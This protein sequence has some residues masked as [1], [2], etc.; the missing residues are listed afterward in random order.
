V[1]EDGTLTDSMRRKVNFKNTMLIM[2]SN[3]GAQQI[4]G[5][6]NLGFAKGDAAETHEKMRSTVMDEVKRAF[7]P[8][9]LNRID[10]VIVFHSLSREDNEKILEILLDEVR[11][12]LKG[13]RYDLQLT[14]PA[15]GLLLEKGFDPKYGARPLRRAIQRLIEDPLSELVLM[16]KFPPGSVIRI[17]RRGDELTFDLKAESDERESQDDKVRSGA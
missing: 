10:E 4:G 13:H 11:L 9:F 16:G 1:L 8:E 17:G 3:L 7:N 14:Q 5:K 15:T 12:R 6:A 2:T